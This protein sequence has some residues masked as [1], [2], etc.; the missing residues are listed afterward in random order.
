MRIAIVHEWLATYAGSERVL[1]QL[2]R[3]Y[4]Q[5]DLYAVV[6][7]LPPDRRDFLGGRVP[8]TSLV[9][10][11]PFARR[12]FRAYLPLMP[13]AMGRLDLRGYDLVISSSH[14]VA[15]GVRTDPRHLHVC[16][17]YS[18]MRYAWDL[19]EQYLQARGLHRGLRG[20]AVR[21]MLARLRAWD[22][23]SA[24]GVTRFVADSRHIADR[25]RRAYGRESDVILPP[26]D[27]EAFPLREDKDDFYL[28]VARLVAYKRVELIVEAFRAMPTRRLV[29]I[30]TGPEA[31]RVRAAAA[32]AA[33][34]ALLGEQPFAAV[35]DHMQRARA[36]LHAGVEDFGIALAE[37][38]ACGT[39]V[40]AYGRGGALDIVHDV[41]APT[42]T[43]LLFAEQTPASLCEGVERFE[44][45]APPISPH[46]C[47]ANAE[48]MGIERFREQIVAFIERAW[49]DS[50]S[51]ESP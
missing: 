24:A 8:H 21:R 31:S 39:P 6:D 10:H 26:V 42:P 33:N 41:G 27:V 1:E 43:G 46:A 23:R 18:P 34:I 4:P 28:T 3:C 30:G 16:Y 2:L 29:V 5:A 45:L 12:H 15:K 38:Q 14:A 40:I 17:C 32:G 44:R 48:A 13:W 36:F 50:G 37:A 51:R 25:I 47:R 9:Q 22:V 49:Q 7:F 20:W 35:R 11:L 19:Q